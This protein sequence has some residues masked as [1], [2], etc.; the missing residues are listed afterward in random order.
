MKPWEYL[1][2]MSNYFTYLKMPKDILPASMEDILDVYP[3][4]ENE[5][6][7]K[8]SYFAHYAFP[9]E[10]ISQEFKDI[11]AQTNMVV[12][13]AEIFYRPGV[14]EGFDAFIHTDGHRIVHGMAKINFIIGGEHNI[15]SWYIPNVPVTD[16]H[17]KTTNVGTKYLN[18][19]PNE[20]DLIGETELKGLYIVNAGIPHGV[21]MT[22]GGINKP[23]ICISL[24]PRDIK[25]LENIGC[26]DAYLR[27]LKGFYKMG[28]ITQ[29]Y[30]EAEKSRVLND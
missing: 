27:L 18:F 23:R 17:I 30:Y 22:E 13:H 3:W 15:M 19:E 29:E 1:K 10:R 26:Y 24:V 25:T 9:V 8:Y 2:I 20:V 21:K 5:V 4:P 14:G 12:K 7:E 28:H 16:D 11:L 6:G